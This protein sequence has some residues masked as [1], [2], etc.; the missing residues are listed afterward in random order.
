MPFKRNQL[1]RIAK[2]HNGHVDGVGIILDDV[3]N[4]EGKLKIKTGDLVLFIE[5]SR[6]TDE[7]E[8]VAQ[9]RADFEVTGQSRSKKAFDAHEWRKRWGSD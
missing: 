6:L 2:L 3:P 4:K 5:V 9:G 1:V 7:K 8:A